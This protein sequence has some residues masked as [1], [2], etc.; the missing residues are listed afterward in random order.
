M[1]S[2]A[3]DNYSGVHP[4]VLAALGAANLDHDRA[5]GDDAWTARAVKKMQS[6]FRNSPDVFLVMNGSGANVSALSCLVQSFESV[7]ATENSHLHQDECG[8]FEKFTG[9]KVRTVPSPGAKLSPQSIEQLLTRQGD[10]HFSQVRAVTIT[11]CTEYGTL[12][13]VEEI[14]AIAKVCKAHGLYLH[15]DG[16]RIAN[17]A[18]ALGLPVA[19]FTEKLG[20]D[21]LSFGGTKNGL[22]LGEAVVFFNKVLAKNYKYHRKQS[23]QLASKMRF[24][25]AQFVALL[26]NDLY[27]ANARAANDQAQ[28]LALALQKI[29]GITL[30][31]KVEANALFLKLPPKVI[32]PLQKKFPFYVWDENTHEIRLMCSFDTSSADIKNFVLELRKLLKV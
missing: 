22:M 16:A 10:Q 6:L 3:S 27:L 31:Q 20:V 18:V 21:V 28:A 23:L 13:S 26:E 19:D 17:A 32:A 5:Y 8:A 25:A 9:S 2:F 29:P 4:K 7:I 24:I 30:S 11:Q 12:Y 1:K 14:K 15:M